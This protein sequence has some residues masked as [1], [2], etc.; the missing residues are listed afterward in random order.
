[1][2]YQDLMDVKI[3]TGPRPFWVGLDP[4]KPEPLG[5]ILAALHCY[6][7]GPP[8][9]GQLC[10]T[11]TVHSDD[12]HRI[13]NGFPELKKLAAVIHTEIP[14]EF[15]PSTGK[16]TTMAA[17]R[18]LMNLKTNIWH[19]LAN[20]IESACR[21]PEPV[22]P[23]AHKVILDHYPKPDGPLAHKGVPGHHPDYLNSFIVRSVPGKSD[24]ASFLDSTQAGR[25]L[26]P[27]FKINHV[28]GMIPNL[29]SV[30]VFASAGNHKG[31]GT[32]AQYFA[33]YPK[34]MRTVVA[35][36]LGL[37]DNL[38]GDR[39]LR[40][41]AEFS[42]VSVFAMVD[43][44]VK[45]VVQKEPLST[46][47]GEIKLWLS[48][49]IKSD[50]VLDLPGEFIRPIEANHHLHYHPANI[51]IPYTKILSYLGE[52]LTV[53]DPW[54]TSS[55]V[56]SGSGDG[57]S[58]NPGSGGSGSNPGSGGSGSN[59]S[60]GNKRSLS[61]LAGGNKQSFSTLAGSFST[62]A[63]GNKTFGP[64]A[65]NTLLARMSGSHDHAV[66]RPRRIGMQKNLAQA[67]V[68]PW[69]RILARIPRKW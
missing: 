27:R 55:S 39:A 25:N 23:L 1:M 5:K 69:S 33:K 52:S 50:D 53:I 30:F 10:F 45:V 26:R 2:G 68:A 64:A 15:D 41:L 49:L 17:T 32:Y 59:H 21:L 13:H 63:G 47:G 57:S 44:K 35:V 29:T 6:H 36:N 8:F 48:D 22:G 24:E 18:V 34:T 54:P 12:H 43:G 42:S 60:S 65:P 37:P 66:F 46:P 19:L 28:P 20:H 40:R 7:A 51:A 9:D 11:F 67:M 31:T 4:D 62:L 38:G 14:F 56:L 58:S 3:A 16:L 61:T